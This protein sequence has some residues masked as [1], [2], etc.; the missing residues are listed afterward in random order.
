MIDNRK[1]YHNYE[2]LDTFEAGM[3]LEGWEVKSLRA[4]KGSLQGAYIRFIN[5]ILVLKDMHISPYKYG[6]EVHQNVYRD[7]KILLTKKEI[8]MLI[9]AVEEKKMSIIP[10]QIH[11]KGRYIKVKIGVGRGLKKHDKKDKLKENDI[12]RDTQKAINMA[13]RQGFTL[14]E[15]LIVIGIIGILMGIMIPQLRSIRSTMTLQNTQKDIVNTLQEAQ[16]YAR[17]SGVDSTIDIQ[18]NGI[19]GSLSP[20]KIPSNITI[21]PPNMRIIFTKP[22]GKMDIE[23][24]DVMQITLKNNDKEAYIT[25]IEETNYIGTT[26]YK[27]LI[28]DINTP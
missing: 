21:D 25:L 10:L 16:Q 24:S 17:N 7:R 23:G 12:K 14:I 8:D 5:D 2:I 3:V 22:L 13:M 20:I 19:T 11:T 4:S 26:P 9:R 15:M 27:T 28:K 6:T 1:A 18:N